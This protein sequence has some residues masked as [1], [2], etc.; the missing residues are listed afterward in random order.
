MKIISSD[1]GIKSNIIKIL[2]YNTK[3][4]EARYFKVF[5]NFRE[6]QHRFDQKIT[7]TVP[8]QVE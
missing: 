2:K 8:F 6:I 1:K 3:S 4:N 5:S 7:K